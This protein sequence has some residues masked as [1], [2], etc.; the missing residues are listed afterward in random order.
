MDA[1]VWT[2]LSKTFAVFTKNWG[3]VSF[4]EFPHLYHNLLINTQF[5]LCA[6]IFI[7]IIL[8]VNKYLVRCK[9]NITIY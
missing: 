3:E 8:C 1:N 4:L 6:Y 5:L 7:F 9:L 2:K